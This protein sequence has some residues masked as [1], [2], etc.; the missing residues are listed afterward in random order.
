MFKEYEIVRLKRDVSGQGVFAGDVGV[1]V[2]VYD[3]SNHPRAYE[4]D[5]S[6]AE[7]KELITV[8]LYEED[9]EKIDEL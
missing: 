9:I 1:V 4:V 7:E 5:F 6:N 8:T 3:V 2:I